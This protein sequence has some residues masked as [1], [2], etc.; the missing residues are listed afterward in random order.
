[1]RASSSLSWLLGGG[2]RAGHEGPGA[3]RRHHRRAAAE[4][5]ARAARQRGA[6]SGRRRQHAPW[7][8]RR[9]VRGRVAAQR[10]L[11]CSRIPHARRRRRR[12]RAVGRGGQRRRVWRAA[13][14]CRRTWRDPG[15]ALCTDRGAWRA[16]GALR[17]L[18]G[19][20]RRASLRPCHAPLQSAAA[21]IGYTPYPTLCCGAP[22]L[23]AGPE[24]RVPCMRVH[25]PRAWLSLIPGA[26]PAADEAGARA[27]CLERYREKKRRRLFAKTIRYEKR[28]VNADN[29]CAPPLWGAAV[30]WHHQL[31]HGCALLGN[32]ERGCVWQ[33][34]TP[35]MCHPSACQVQV[36][37]RRAGTL[38][39]AQS[40]QPGH[41]D[42]GN[43]NIP[44][45]AMHQ[46]VAHA[47]GASRPL[48]KA[49]RWLL[50]ARLRLRV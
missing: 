14:T 7:T 6:R 50:H 27:G 15:V 47:A 8:R 4:R 13:S 37:G 41:H 30:P 31:P 28:K 1:V 24:A 43:H 39:R 5:A 22:G 44:V 3:P 19:K 11:R 2:R 16:G 38:Q 49:R 45:Q 17:L 12:R 40:T 25:S 9:S 46:N 18:P 42:S 35:P 36:P 23:A 34:C 21:R 48:W 29:R 10:R 32:A 33:A 20:R 26:R